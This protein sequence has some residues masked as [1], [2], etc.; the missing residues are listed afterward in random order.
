MSK[1]RENKIEWKIGERAGC[2]PR[3]AMM[4]AS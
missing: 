1:R 4:I 3:Q 2:V